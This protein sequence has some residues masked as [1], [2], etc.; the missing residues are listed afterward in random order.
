VFHE[1]TNVTAALEHSAMVV[2]LNRPEKRNVLSVE[3][4]SEL[5]TVLADCSHTPTVR[6]VIIAA[7]GK[8]F[9][10]GHDLRELSGRDESEYQK[11]FELCTELM[12]AIQS[13][14]VPIIA[15]VQGIA[16][17]AGC[18][19]VAACDLAIASTD[20][21]FATPGV[22]I[23]LFCT[24][25]M[26]P[27]VRAI[28]RKRAMQMLMTGN[29][30]DSHTA[31]EWGLIN[32]AV[33]PGQLRSATRELA[34]AIALASRETVAIGKRAFYQQIGLAETAAYDCAK[35]TMTMNALTVDAQEGISAFLAKRTP[36]WRS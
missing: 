19:L 24:T 9:C 23:G 16:T 4:M 14:P 29:P 12:L 26:V 33:A 5:M 31:V 18:Q 22:N 17:A 36:V 6:T 15:E 20:A 10:A 32:D 30:I 34:A 25:P 13:M 11:I 28:G 35:E 7:A 27:L 8:A 21:T 1:F 2:T 3:T